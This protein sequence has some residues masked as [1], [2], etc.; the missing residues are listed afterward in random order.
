MLSQV[1]LHETGEQRVSGAG[2]GWDPGAILTRQH[3][4]TQRRPGDQPHAVT[5]QSRDHFAF[6][7]ALEQAVLHLR[8]DRSEVTGDGRLHRSDGGDLPAG[9][10]ADAD[11]MDLARGHR[12]VDGAQRLVDRGQGV[13]GMQLPQVDVLDAE[14]AQ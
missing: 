2:V 6:H 12:R 13:P 8:A 11:V 10:V 1:G 7:A 5:L 14:P 9:I 3:S 4:A